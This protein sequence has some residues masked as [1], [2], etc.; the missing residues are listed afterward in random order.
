MSETPA[1]LRA[2]RVIYDLQVGGVQR[3]MLRSI[4]GLRSLGVTCEV[5]CLRRRGALAE[6]FEAQGFR[7]R[8][9]GF[10]TRLD[11]LGMIR[12]RR[13]IRAGRF[14]VVHSHMYASN[15]AV[16]LA[17]LGVSGVGIINGYHSTTP[18]TNANQRRFMRWVRNLPH[19][20]IAVGETVRDEILENGA[21]PEKVTV[22]HNG[23][24]V[25]PAPDPL[26]AR[27]PGE[28]LQLLWAGRYVT[29]KRMDV[30]VE[31]M[32]RCRERGVPARVTLLGDGPKKPRIEEAIREMGLG[33]WIATPGVS[34]DV[35][36][37]LHRSDLYM[38]PSAREGFP[39]A[40]LEAC[41]AARGAL[42][43]DIP[44][45]RDAL[46]ADGSVGILLPAEQPERWVDAIAALAADR[47]RVA[48]MGAAAYERSKQFSIET[49]CRKMRALY[50]KAVRAARR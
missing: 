19:A 7:V 1:P 30:F 28:P 14:D 35:A 50:D 29:E 17:L 9:L 49:A 5:C 21:P 33:E 22:L 36:G 25:P 8:C 18:A 27:A 16:D 23:I 15:I 47:A 11:P 34:H 41:A 10:R 12:L 46:G 31:V 6:T 40:L 45:H 4:T 3:Q 38:T 13:L 43:S 26:P 37:W 32:A 48:A 24:A 39:N 2:L 44:T 42:A 20:Y